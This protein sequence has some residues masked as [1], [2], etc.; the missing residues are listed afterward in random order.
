MDRTTH[1]RRAEFVFELK[2][3]MFH[4]VLGTVVAY[5][6]Y[7][8]YPNYGNL[9]LIPLLTALL[10]M[11]ILPRLPVDH[12]ISRHLLYHFEREQ[13]RRN[14][15]FKGAIYF[16]IGIIPPIVLLPLDM[17]TGR[18]LLACAVIAV[19]AGGDAFAALV[20][21]FYGRYRI[22]HKSIE[23]FIAFIIF[24]Y[25]MATFLFVD[26][27]TAMFLAII[28]AIIEFWNTIDDNLAIPIGLTIVIEVANAIVP[29][30][31]FTI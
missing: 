14:F 8:L 10:I 1:E 27:R 15:P 29:N 31:L 21:K 7:F 23:G 18:P 11:W 28:G 6:V 19:L 26:M 4:F 2:R 3:K 16:G 5:A 20:G 25:M 13:D 9:L 17:A 24:S 22:G 12:I 30:V